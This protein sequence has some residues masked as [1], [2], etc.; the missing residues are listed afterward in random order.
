VYRIPEANHQARNYYVIVEA[1]GS[2]GNVLSFPVYSEEDGRAERVN[3]WGIRVDQ[4]VYDRIRADKLDDGIIQNNRFGEKRKGY[5]KPDYAF[6]VQS[7]TIL[8]W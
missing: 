7:G 5:L 6:P 1:V 2:D 3:R 4:A 8:E